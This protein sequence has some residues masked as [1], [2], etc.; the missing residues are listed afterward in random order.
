MFAFAAFVVTIAIISR[1]MK[2][3]AIANALPTRKDNQDYM[4]VVEERQQDSDKGAKQIDAS[5]TA[6]VYL[7]PIQV[8][9]ASLLSTRT[10]VRFLKLLALSPNE[11][12]T[13]IHHQ[14]R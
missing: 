4:K 2:R 7:L 3:L 1:V 8:K 9:I 14:P 12:L 13:I 11:A 5:T 10:R 6:T